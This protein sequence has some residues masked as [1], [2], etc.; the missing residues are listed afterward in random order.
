MLNRGNRN[1]SR[2]SPRTLLR[3]LPPILR[4]QRTP[5]SLQELQHDAGESIG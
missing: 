5:E 1:H 3:G 4:L 2:T